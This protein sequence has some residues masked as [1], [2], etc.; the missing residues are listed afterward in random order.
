MSERTEADVDRSY[1][2]SLEDRLKQLK[3]PNAPKNAK[4]STFLSDLN[5]AKNQHLF[6][7]LT[8]DLAASDRSKP[9]EEVPEQPLEANWLQRKV[10]PQTCAINAE[11]RHKL[12]K[13]DNLEASPNPAAAGGVD[14]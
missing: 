14:R 4:S 5:S 7:L 2:K 10:A 12:V 11:E 6:Q 8:S 9:A 13:H 1:L 3:D